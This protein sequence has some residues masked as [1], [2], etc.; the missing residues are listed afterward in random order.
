[1]AKKTASSP[2][3]PRRRTAAPRQATASDPAAAHTGVALA[4]PSEPSH[5]DIAYAAYL[6]YL[7]RG[8]SDGQDF[9]DWLLAEQDLK[10]QTNGG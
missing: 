7:S 10:K 2:T 5:D 6:R 4:D 9:D 1:M 8:G 3:A